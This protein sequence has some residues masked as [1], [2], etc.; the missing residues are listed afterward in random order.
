M[1]TDSQKAYRDELVKHGL[2]ISMGVDGLYGR[3]GTFESIVEAVDRYVTSI[4]GGDGAEVMR[5]PPGISRQIF[6][7]SE[8]LKSFPQLAGTVHSFM[9]NDRDH[10]ALLEQL[11]SKQDWT[12]QQKATQIVLTPAA[13]YPVY[14]TLSK[15]GKLPKNGA[16]VDVFSY[17]FRHEPSIEPTRQ[18]L[19]R[20]REYIRLGSPE[21]VQEFRDTWMKRGE[22]MMSELGLPVTMDVANDPFFGRP[23]RMLAANQ[24][25]QAL[26]FELLIPVGS[27]EQLTACLSFN[28]HKDKFATNWKLQQDSEEPAHTA[29]VGFGMERITLALLK[30]HG[31][32][33]GSWSSAVR[34][35]L[36]P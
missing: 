10:A 29:C 7:E 9:G 11:E 33:P 27:T 36:W 21:Q 23:G 1:T 20:M 2:L 14:P 18:Q 25:E 17:C 35:K 3:S 34:N 26:K 16:L 4:G 19:F 8:Y 24:R 28:Y 22:K 13:C 30:H 31:F 32:D 15:R 12:G 6:E 5:F